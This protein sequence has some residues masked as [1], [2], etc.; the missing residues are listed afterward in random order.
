M[1]SDPVTI[2][3]SKTVPAGMLMCPPV[4]AMIITDPSNENEEER[5]PNNI[6]KLN[7]FNIMKDNIN[8]LTLKSNTFPESDISAKS[9]TIQFQNI[10]DT[11]CR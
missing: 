10:W 3:F 6:W 1:R 5:Y 9:Q 11:L 2:L 4:L 7:Y 8:F